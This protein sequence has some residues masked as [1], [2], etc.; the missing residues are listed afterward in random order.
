VIHIDFMMG[1]PDMH[2]T[3]IQE[4]GTEVTVFENGDFAL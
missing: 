1:T 4:D 3:G 2:I